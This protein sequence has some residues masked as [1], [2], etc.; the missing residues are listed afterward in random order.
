M[1][2]MDKNKKEEDVIR[3]KLGTACYPEHG[4]PLLIYIMVHCG[5][6]L[7]KCLLLNANCGGDNVGRGAILGLLLGATVTGKDKDDANYKA[8]EDLK[9]GLTDYK[10]IENEIEQFVACVFK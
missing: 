3:H 9:K 1:G 6:D 8:L 10:D 2:E 7:K 4:I 5:F